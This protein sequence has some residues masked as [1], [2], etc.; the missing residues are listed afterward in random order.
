[1]ERRWIKEKGNGGGS[2]IKGR[3]GR[4]GGARLALLQRMTESRKNPL[5]EPSERK[6]REE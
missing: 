6:S 5:S 4:E 3:G 1:V 2:K